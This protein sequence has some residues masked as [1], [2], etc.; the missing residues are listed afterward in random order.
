[1]LQKFSAQR[2]SCLV[3]FFLCLSSTHLRGDESQMFPA[4]PGAEGAG[5][6]TPGGRGGRVLAVTTLEDY[7]PGHEKPVKGSL[8]AALMARG[9]RI[10]IFRVSGNIVLKSELAIEE[11][12]VTVAGQSAPGG[13]ICLTNFG[14]KIQTHDVVLRYIRIRPGDVEQ[15]ENDAVS[16]NARNVIIDHCSTSWAIDEVLSTNGDSANLTVQWCLITESLNQSFHHKGSHGYGSLISG[17]GEIS[18][19]H[20]LY[21]Y[22]RSRNPRPGRVRLDFRNNLV[23]AW[24]DRA[25]YC[26]NERLEMNYVANMLWPLAYSKSKEFAFLPGGLNPRIYLADNRYHAATAPA[27]DQWSFIRT[28]E[29]FQPGEAKKL[30][31]ATHLFPTAEV[32]SESVE[33]AAERILSEGGASKPARDAVDE[34]VTHQIRNGAGKLINSQTE[35]GGWPEL[36]STTPPQDQDGDGMP[37]EWETRYQLDPQKK[38]DASADQDGD[39]YT[40]IEEFL[41]ETDPLTPE[42]WVYPPTI[43]ASEG[44]E[45]ITSNRITLATS[46]PGAEI[47]YTT[48]DSLPT[49]SSPHYS[50]PFDLDR[51]ATVRAC[52]FLDGRRSHVHNK[53]LE[54]LIWQEPVT[55]AKLQPGVRYQ[56]YLHE[57]WDDFPDFASLPVVAS[58]IEPLISLEPRQQENGFGL[59]WTGF[60]SAPREGIYRFQLRCSPTGQLLMHDQLLLESQGRRRQRSAAVALKPGLHPITFQIYYKNDDDKTFTLE[61]EGPGIPM[62]SLPAE[63]LFSS[64]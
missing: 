48:D 30:M 7:R 44:D 35:V 24:G 62:Q 60:F 26:G 29:R 40:D 46:T 47:H 50:A 59:R 23:A 39:G 8:R 10:I 31:Q 37:D 61:C 52:A 55:E 14:L 18:Y 63:F 15:Q 9:P 36:Q 56:Y 5:A 20:N 49:L 6:Y 3:A 57:D 22:H 25:G 21:A 53:F 51:S 19:H 42:L 28:P 16:C 43:Q 11:P 4:F 13:G 2:F 33:T 27:A 64:K 32:T 41:N 38:A 12:F 34:R 1:M 45:F 17:P 58:G 54:H